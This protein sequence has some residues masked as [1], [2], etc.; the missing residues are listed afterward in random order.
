MDALLEPSPVG[1]RGAVTAETGIRTLGSVRMPGLA[2][3][4]ATRSHPI[5]SLRSGERAENRVS[6][7]VTR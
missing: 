6:P 2:V 5:R 1:F 3:P 7:A 4:V